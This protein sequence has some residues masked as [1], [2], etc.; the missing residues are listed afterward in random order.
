MKVRGL[1]VMALLA[2]ACVVYAEDVEIDDVQLKRSLESLFLRIHSIS[3]E[4][5]AIL[6]N[7]HFA[8]NRLV[9]AAKAVYADANTES[10][11]KGRAISLVGRYGTPQDVDFL[12]SCASN[13]DFWCNSS[14]G[15]LSILGPT[16]NGLSRLDT[17]MR[18]SA[19]TNGEDRLE[20]DKV[21][22][23]WA[24]LE[25]AAKPGVS[26]DDR[27]RAWDYAFA[28]ASNHVNWARMN[29]MGLTSFDKSFAR[30]RRRLELL[31]YLLPQIKY[32]GTRDYVASEIGKL[33]ALPASDLAE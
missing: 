7:I 22:A 2:T 33:E 32:P 25:H 17:L 18:H 30:S 27:R 8:S 24:L 5:E 10:L 28:F 29:D 6:S 31:R 23:V 3:G 14:M 12:M 1:L 20:R 15:V 16:S 4:R 9:S 26:P 11:Q 19:V 21:Y 13:S